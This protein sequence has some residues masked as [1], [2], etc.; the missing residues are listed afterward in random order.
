MKK[1]L[2][3]ELLYWQIAVEGIDVLR[4]PENGYE[5]KNKTNKGERLSTFI[6]EY[7]ENVLNH[8]KTG[9]SLF[10][11]GDKFPAIK[12]T[13]HD[14]WWEQATNLGRGKLDSNMD[15][16]T[17]E[18]L[19]SK[20]AKEIMNAL[21]PAYKALKESFDRRPFWHWFT[22]HDEYTA[23]RDSIRALRGTMMSLF[24]KPSEY[25]EKW[26]EEFCELPVLEA[27]DHKD[28]KRFI[29]AARDD[30]SRDVFDIIDD[31][32]RS[33]KS[34][35]DGVLAD[36][37]QD[38]EVNKIMNGFE[39]A[40]ANSITPSMSF[41]EDD[42]LD[43]SIDDIQ[44]NDKDNAFNTDEIE[45]LSDILSGKDNRNNNDNII[46]EVDE[47]DELNRTNVSFPE[48]S[49]NK[50]DEKKL[51]PVVEEGSFSKTKIL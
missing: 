46:L 36:G 10:E 17:L 44:A 1:D 22:R 14:K 9:V 45:E 37:L 48:L 3:Q 32:P 8:R 40:L 25:V 31:D 6:R 23:E 30:R 49:E 29:K 16:P 51:S 43:F 47:D 7:T 15:L 26:Y 19:D 34:S 4:I 2:E 12:G 24:Q 13:T 28:R 39:D 20:N 50:E 5:A 38:E 21:F 35:T 18:K 11:F 41:P 42:K 33:K 27:Y